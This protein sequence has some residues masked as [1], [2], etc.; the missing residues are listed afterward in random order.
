M[1]GQSGAI[2]SD[3]TV[4]LDLNPMRSGLAASPEQRDFTSAQ[5]RIADLKSPEGFP[6]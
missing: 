2:Q 3:L 6:Q 5:K 4:Y 1:D